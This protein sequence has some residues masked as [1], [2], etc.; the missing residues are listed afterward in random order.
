MQTIKKKDTVHL[1][2]L[3]F[4]HLNIELVTFKVPPNYCFLWNIGL[5][6]LARSCKREKEREKE[7]IPRRDNPCLDFIAPFCYMDEKQFLI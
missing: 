5:C 6:S 1:L 4:K 7:E 2:L 3:G